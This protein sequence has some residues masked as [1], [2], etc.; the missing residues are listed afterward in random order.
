MSDQVLG[1]LILLALFFFLAVALWLLSIRM[2]DWPMLPE[3][4][5][6]HFTTDYQNEPEAFDERYD[7]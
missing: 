7:R 4:N 1:L 5:F 3:M 6:L 2:G